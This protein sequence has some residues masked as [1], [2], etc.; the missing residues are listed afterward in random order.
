M[1]AILI[2]LIF[3]ASVFVLG[4]Y[5]ILGRWWSNRAGIAYAVLVGSLAALS[6]FFLIEAVE[7]QQPQWVE[8]SALGLVAAALLWN[9]YA[10]I[11]KQL[12]YWRI[13]GA[14]EHD[15]PISKEP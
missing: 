8:D 4:A 14:P 6:L 2:G 9:A 12:H 1:T 13:D 15:I 11:W 5:T 7:G 10:V 3:T